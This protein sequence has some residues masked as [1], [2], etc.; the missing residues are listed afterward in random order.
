[1]IS[2][3]TDCLLSAAEQEGGSI[4]DLQEALAGRD[5]MSTIA[6]HGEPPFGDSSP[7][8]GP[9][10]APVSAEQPDFNT[11]LQGLAERVSRESAAVSPPAAAP[12]PAPTLDYGAM[13]AGLAERTPVA[14]GAVPPERSA[15][16]GGGGLDFAAMMAGFSAGQGASSKADEEGPAG[17]ANFMSEMSRCVIV[18][19]HPIS[20]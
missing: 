17:G 16:G 13:L 10:P 2:Q 6:E 4:G 7:S 11:R 5:F 12:R 19:P 14:P 3:G 1:M 20:L 18:T 8:T 9:I 15:T